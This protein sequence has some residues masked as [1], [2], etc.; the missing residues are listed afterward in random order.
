M[1]IPES[2]STHQREIEVPGSK[3]SETLQSIRAGGGWVWRM[4]RKAATYTLL[5]HWNVGKGEQ[6]EMKL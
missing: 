4:G 5:V 2:I 3:L 6:R 1:S